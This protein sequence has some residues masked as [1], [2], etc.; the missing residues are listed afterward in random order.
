VGCSHFA[1]TNH[2][3]FCRSI[4][5]RY[6][7]ETREPQS[8]GLRQSRQHGRRTCSFAAEGLFNRVRLVARERKGTRIVYF[9][10][11]R[12][13]EFAL[14]RVLGGKNYATMPWRLAAQKAYS[15]AR[16]GGPIACNWYPSFRYKRKLLDN[17][18]DF[19]NNC[20]DLRLVV[21]PVL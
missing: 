16:A 12:Y 11:A 5:C 7:R 14:W 17:S 9:D 10:L 3:C 1:V 15:E 2:F 21:P 4:R 20:Q 13:R 8:E 18:A 19:S 6:T